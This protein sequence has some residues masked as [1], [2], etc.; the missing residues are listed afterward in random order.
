MLLFWTWIYLM[1]VSYFDDFG[2]LLYLLDAFKRTNQKAGNDGLK[3]PIQYGSISKSFVTNII[4]IVNKHI[5]ITDRYFPYL[6]INTQNDPA[7]ID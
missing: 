5:P 7:N 6:N 4:I 1:N 2:F 3:N